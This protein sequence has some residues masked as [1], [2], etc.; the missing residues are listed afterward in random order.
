MIF[1]I[2]IEQSACSIFCFQETKRNS[3]DHQFMRNFSHR[4]FDQYAFVPS[5]GASGGILTARNGALFSG[6]VVQS[7][8]FALT[9]KSIST[10]DATVWYVTNNYGPSAV[11]T[12]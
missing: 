6:T 10:Q 12:Y 9:I 5:I 4:R 8:R 7:N 11:S 2:K 1:E 3:F